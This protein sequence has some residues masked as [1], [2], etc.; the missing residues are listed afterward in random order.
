MAV[1]ATA[2]ITLLRVN[3]G[4]K[5][6]TGKTALQPLKN[7]QSTYTTIGGTAS[8][9]KSTF[10]RDPVVGDVFTNID[11]SSNI[12]TWQIVAINGSTAVFKLLSYVNAKGTTGSNGRGIKSTAITYQAWSNGTSTPT[13][14]WSTTPPKTTASAPYLWT[15]IFITYTDGTS[16]TSYSVGSTPE[17]IQ[18]GCR[19]LLVGTNQGTKYWTN[20]S[21]SS[22][23]YSI[24][25]VSWM[26]TNAV[27]MS[28]RTVSTSW[29]MFTFNGL[30][31]N[32]DK[33]KPNGIYT[34]SYDTNNAEVGVDLF[35]L[36]DSSATNTLIDKAISKNDEVTDYG[37]R[38]VRV[39]RLKG[40]LE[41]KKQVVYLNNWLK[42]GQSVIIANLKMEEGNKATD[43]TPAPEDVD[44]TIHDATNNVITQMETKLKSA[45]DVTNSKINTWV[46]EI[47]KTETQLNDLQT[48][49]ISEIR[50]DLIQQKDSIEFVTSTT[51]QIEN[52]LDGTATKEE[53][54][55]WA[56]YKDGQLELGESNSRFKSIL[57][58]TEL[59]F[60][61]DGTKIAYISNNMMYILKAK[62]QERLEI[63]S[64]SLIDEGDLGFSIL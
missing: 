22:G 28:C 21:D 4:A 42:A 55:K 37:K 7:F 3:D 32:F 25:S 20:D 43:W 18:V 26:N 35:N 10:N 6:E 64:F 5:G 36:C 14:T 50:S 23:V 57:T 19:N 31:K 44:D 49:T 59:G 39:F 40:T 46:S 1:K 56:R 41:K 9:D 16:S 63:G 12:G 53:I 2:L 15:K 17:G 52:V 47:Q 58:N 11:A 13:G 54:S 30:L 45:I 29:K 48:N 62:I 24:E 27:K 61:Q 33:L 34:V 51:K 38:Y 60:Y 8:W